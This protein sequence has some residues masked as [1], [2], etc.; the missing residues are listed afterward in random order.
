MNFLFLI[1][2]L[3]PNNVIY[4]DELFICWPDRTEKFRQKST[5]SFIEKFWIQI[6]KPIL[7]TSILGDTSDIVGCFAVAEAIS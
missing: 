6:H 1:V 7:W 4:N 3:T 2:L 5:E